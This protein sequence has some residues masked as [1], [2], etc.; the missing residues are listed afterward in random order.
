MIIKRRF[1]T[2]GQLCGDEKSKDAI[3]GILEKY[4]VSQDIFEATLDPYNGIIVLNTDLGSGIPGKAYQEIRVALDE[5]DKTNPF[6]NGLTYKD[7]SDIRTFT[8]RNGAAIMQVLYKRRCEESPLIVQ[9]IAFEYKDGK[10]VVIEPWE[11][12]QIIL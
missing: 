1:A 8:S 9:V 11:I 4:K 2:Y 7:V 3:S 6:E 12:G 10:T 5:L